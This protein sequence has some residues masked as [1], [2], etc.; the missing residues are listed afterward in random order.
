MSNPLDVALHAS[1]SE[2]ASGNS[3]A[4]DIGVLR[5][6]LAWHVRVISIAGG[7]P[8]A[9]F[10]IQTSPDGSTGWRDVQTLTAITS[11]SRVEAAIDGLERYVRLAWTISGIT[12]FEA[13]GAAHVLHATRAH[14]NAGHMG[15]TAYGSLDDTTVVG[16]LIAASADVD[17][18][19]RKAVPL[20]LTAACPTTVSERGA[21]IALY[22]I[23]RR[24]GFKPNEVDEL[25]VKDS[26]DAFR[27]LRDVGAK[28][29]VPEGFAPA[30]VV[31][32]RTST[33]NPDDTTTRKPRMSDNWGDFG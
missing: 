3:A 7:S 31:A 4:F 21:A 12:V 14:V 26:D 20:P 16:I 8:S 30:A 28:K 11:A 24:R 27:W 10:K 5:S 23:M 1:G 33:G 15:S 18:H 2:A 22:R 6:A 19:I 17:D 29:I 32:V 25:I 9:I 13:A